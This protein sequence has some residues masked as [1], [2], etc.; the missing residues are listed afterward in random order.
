MGSRHW[1]LD[2]HTPVACD[3]ITWAYWFVEAGISR[4]VADDRIGS[5]RI[6]TVFRGIDD[7]C[8]DEEPPLLFETM[9]FGPERDQWLDRCSTW[10]EAEAM[11]KRAVAMVTG[12]TEEPK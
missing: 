3:L 12:T 10:E 5:V 2:G 1:I 4:R 6:N 8:G 11:H 9:I 7:R